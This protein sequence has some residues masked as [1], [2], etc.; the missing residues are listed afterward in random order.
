M[1]FFRRDES[2]MSDCPICLDLLIHKETST[3]KE[4]SFETKCSVKELECGHTFHS[5]CISEWFSK[6]KHTCPVCRM[7]VN[8]TSEESGECEQGGEGENGEERGE[9]V[10]DD[11]HSIL[12]RM[13]RVSGCILTNHVLLCFANI[14][15]YMNDG[16]MILFLF[17]M[18]L[19]SPNPY[20]IFVGC[21]ILAQHILY[22]PTHIFV[23]CLASLFTSLVIVYIQ[24]SSN[25]SLFTLRTE[26]DLERQEMV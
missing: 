1:V 20:S 16:D 25:A 9:I 19:L 8:G 10:T 13:E 17:N 7:D 21:V 6:N 12:R 5:E 24:Y 18:L 11:D 22:H 26:T 3:E 15:F 2:K 23:P 14:L 4:C